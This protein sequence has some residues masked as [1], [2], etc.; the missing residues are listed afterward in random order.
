MSRDG[1][2]R[3][4]IAAGRIVEHGGSERIDALDDADARD[5]RRGVL[6]PLMAEQLRSHWSLAWIK[7]EHR[8]YEVDK[9]RLAD[10]RG[11]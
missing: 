4:Q 7:G 9:K 3:Q 2:I 1:Y 11:E 5:G 8:R 6:E 10:V